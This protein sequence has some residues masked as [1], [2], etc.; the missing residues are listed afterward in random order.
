[1]LCAEY[2][3]RVL[4]ILGFSFTI[5][6]LAISSKSAAFTQHAIA[7][8]NE[9][10]ALVD[11]MEQEVEE[12]TQRIYE[13][14]NTDPL[15]GL[16]NRTAFSKNLSKS[17]AELTKSG[18]ELALLFIDLDGFKKINDTF[19]HEAGDQILKASAHR[20]QSITRD[21]N[22]LCRWGGDEFLVAL[23][24]TDR[25]AAIHLGREIIDALSLEHKTDDAKLSVGAT[26]GVALFPIHETCESKLIQHADTAMYYQK[27]SKGSSVC[28][29]NEEMEAE[30]LRELKLKNGLAKAIEKEQLRLVF[31]PIV[32]P[33]DGAP[34][35]FEAL[36]RWQF[37]D[38]NI[39][40][41]QF[42][43]IAEQY[44]LILDIGDWV[45]VQ[46]CHTAAEWQRSK[47]LPVCVNVS[48]I[49]FQDDGFPGMVDRALSESGLAPDCLH[50]EITE[51]VFASDVKLLRKRIK[52][53]QQRGIHVSIDDFGTGYSSL[54]VMQ[55]LAV[56]TVKIDRSFI[57]NLEGSSYAIVTAVIHAAS[58]MKF[59]VVAEGVETQ[60]QRETLAKL[61]VHKLQGFYFS[62]PLEIDA[63][64]MYLDER[65]LG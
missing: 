57:N 19:G 37:G 13:L 25:E 11:H 4:G 48:V 62:K 5:V 55:D 49:Q 9:N 64:A 50:L 54:S 47:P 24:R 16:Y 12:R 21:S 22:L 1:L 61:G 53:I 8:K 46:A 29:F 18:E 32:S 17:L 14:S 38:E 31:Q 6:M 43:G 63:L 52:A 3:D 27:K 35:S 10:A 59:D 51:S 23:E 2:A 42:I 39:P 15:T 20:L 34:V 30:H 45:M 7:L 36:L 40:P 44:G 26:I 41:D 65:L 60:A 28:V 33:K 58:I 56:D